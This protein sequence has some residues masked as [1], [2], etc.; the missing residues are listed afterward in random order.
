LERGEPDPE[1]PLGKGDLGGFHQLCV[2]KITFQ[3][4]SKFNSN[5]RMDLRSLLLSGKYQ[6][7][8]NPPT[9]EEDITALISSTP[10]PLPFEYLELLRLSDGGEAQL[11]GFPNYVR[12]WSARI[13]IDYNQGYEVQKWLPGF[14]GIGDNGG[15]EMVGFDTRF[16]QPYRVCTI[17]FVPMTWDDLSIDLSDF[18]TFIQR[19]LVKTTVADRN[20]F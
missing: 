11:S 13:A 9:T 7:D 6:W 1:V 18:S 8:G 12:I 10:S 14:I 15:G 20:K 16:G 19:L 3:T 17:A 2:L 5:S 4:P